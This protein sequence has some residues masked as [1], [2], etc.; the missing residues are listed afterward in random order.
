MEPRTV[1]L[2]CRKNHSP[3]MKIN[4]TRRPSTPTVVRITRY[5]R[6]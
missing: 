5:D 3:T 6:T 4:G 2:P 1:T